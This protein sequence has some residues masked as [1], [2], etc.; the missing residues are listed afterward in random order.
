MYASVSGRNSTLESLGSHHVMVTY[1]NFDLN[2][3]F[4]CY[5]YQRIGVLCLDALNQIENTTS[6]TKCACSE[7]P[8]PSK[9]IGS[10]WNL[11]KMSESSEIFGVFRNFLKVQKFLEGSEIFGR[12]QKN[13]KVHKASENFRNVFWNA[14]TRTTWLLEHSMNKHDIKKIY[15]YRTFYS[16]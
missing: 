13:W 11:P 12:F 16:E 14:G 9:K 2:E 6:M 3:L 5:F 7:M 10:F 4:V 8:L 1:I 15:L